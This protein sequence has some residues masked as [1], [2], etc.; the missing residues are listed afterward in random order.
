VLLD[1]GFSEGHYGAHERYT[2]ICTDPQGSGSRSY[3]NYLGF[4]PGVSGHGELTA[5]DFRALKA[6]GFRS[7]GK[8]IKV[9]ALPSNYRRLAESFMAEC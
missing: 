1:A 4:G 2:L 7:L 3:Y 6:E 5:S 8:R 9:E